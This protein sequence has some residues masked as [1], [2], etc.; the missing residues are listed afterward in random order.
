[1]TLPDSKPGEASEEPPSEAEGAL[2]HADAGAELEE[3]LARRGGPPA[4][5]DDF[6]DADDADFDVGAQ[7]FSAIFR[8]D[9]DPGVASQGAMFRGGDPED[10]PPRRREDD[11]AEDWDA[12][13]GPVYQCPADIDGALKEAFGFDEFREGQ[14]EVIE[15]VLAGRDALAIMPTSAGKSLLYQL[16]ALMLPGITL[17]ISP[18]ISLMK[19]QVDKLRQRGLPA[20]LINSALTESERRE[21]I[22][23]ARR[24]RLKLLFIAPERFRS[25]GF[26]RALSELE[27][28][29]FA[30]DEAHCVSTWGHDF[31]TDYRKLPRALEAA[32]RPPVLA[33]TA[34]A[35]ENVRQDIETYLELKEDYFKLLAGFDRP[36]LRFGVRQ[37]DTHED[38]AYQIADLSRRTGGPGIVYCSTRKNTEKIADR[39]RKLELN[40]AVYH[41][42][43]DSRTRRQVQEAFMGGEVPIVCAT[44]AFGLG[45]D[46]QNVRFVAHH[47]LPGSIEAYYQEAGRAGR[48]GQPSECLLLFRPGDIYVQE[49]MIDTSHPTRPLVESVYRELLS[50]DDGQHEIT[51]SQLKG[52][53]LDAKSERTISAALRLLEEADHIDRGGRLDNPAHLRQ[54]RD[55]KPGS[56]TGPQVLLGRLAR[57][58][59]PG[60]KDGVSIP[61][62]EL[63]GL[64]G[65]GLDELRRHLPTLR[66]GG[67]L[68]Y[69]APFAGRSLS[70]RFPRLDI[71][72]LK[73]DY[74]RV[75]ERRE[76]DFRRLRLVID[77]A[78][79]QRCRRATIL[80]YFGAPFEQSCANCDVCAPAAGEDEARDLA[81]HE[82]V[83]LKKTLSCVARMKGRFGRAKVVQ[84]LR[85]SRAKDI[86]EYRLDRLST[87]G[88]LSDWSQ[89]ALT[90]LLG[91]CLKRGLVEE[92]RDEQ[93]RYPKVALTPL[94]RDVVFDR[95][96]VRLEMPEARGSKRSARLGSSSH[97]GSSQ[98]GAAR[99]PGPASRAD[100]ELFQALRS[101]RSEL[102]SRRSLKPFKILPDRSLREIAER[103]PKNQ[104]ELEQ[105]HGIGP[106]KI[107]KFGRIFLD[108]L[109]GYDEGR[110]IDP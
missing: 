104:E 90:G 103:R 106:A 32:G 2:D 31:R 6:D 1:M 79:S 54:L 21:Q 7:P 60:L 76:R 42:G 58:F 95:E 71:P 16:P 5:D 87:H 56:R 25:L 20:G 96:R 22:E 75:E 86:L 59:G 39:L 55:G 4:L 40:A 92:H 77:F 43:L 109:R 73:V 36:N 50:L 89:S 70:V 47:D 51:L 94:G 38:K 83:V 102:A 52:R 35:T 78:Y 11:L 27:V 93:G 10:E 72:Q 66:E 49:F 19:D 100:E 68:E 97:R 84:V 14:R 29:L 23:A 9:A 80:D 37:V 44:N 46:K 69:R 108:F 33:V 30:V 99:M 101:L 3:W 24:G 34:T 74:Q 57:V 53:I 48:D 61:L 28:S 12:L 91:E 82:L 17:V 81:P 110:A 107:K 88:L 18:L 45:I 62:P 105:V 64:V 67:F 13:Y 63:A 98:R 8:E 26:R 65:A 85:G 15:A 41:A